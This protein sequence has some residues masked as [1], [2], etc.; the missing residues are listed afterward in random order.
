[1]DAVEA[2]R[3]T[4]ARSKAAWSRRVPALVRGL[5]YLYGP[6]GQ[7]PAPLR[8]SSALRLASAQ[9]GE[10]VHHVQESRKAAAR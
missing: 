4:W 7:R 10:A 1:M 5:G 3:R 9:I 2:A 6:L 8:E